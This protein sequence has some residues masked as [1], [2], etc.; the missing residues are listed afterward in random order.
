MS[1]L[2]NNRALL[3]AFR[4][5]DE[6]SLATIY[7]EYAD[8]VLQLL[9]YGFTDK[10][11]G[12]FICG[13][14]DANVRLDCLQDIFCKA[15]SLQARNSYDGVRL[16]H[17]Y[18]MSIARNRLIDHWRVYVRDPVAGRATVDEPEAL[19]RAMNSGREDVG[20]DEADRLHWQRCLDASDAFFL[21]IDSRQQQFVTMRFREEKPLL[22]V[23]RALKMSRWKARVLEKKLQTN[24]KKY[25]QREG[26][27]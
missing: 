27:L 6:A 15:F 25:L 17:Y 1:L 5:G 11:K 16:Y 2:I 19:E 4:R 24:L 14:A 23:A 12:S 26:L 20:V 22:E 21:Q 8:S 3:D 9:R 10:H 7:R 18:L 13:I